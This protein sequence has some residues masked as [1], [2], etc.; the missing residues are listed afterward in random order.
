MHFQCSGALFQFLAFFF[1]K[2]F[3]FCLCLFVFTSPNGEN[4]RRPEFW[5]VYMFNVQ[6]SLKSYRRKFDLFSLKV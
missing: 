2:H 6:L 5:N 4:K 1:E 3:I